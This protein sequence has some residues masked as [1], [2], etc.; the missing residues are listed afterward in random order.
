[1]SESL[2]FSISIT[3]MEKLS[4]TYSEG[5]VKFFN[6]QGQNHFGHLE[7]SYD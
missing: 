4:Y 2:V 6:E 7:D 5:I 3:L 1:M